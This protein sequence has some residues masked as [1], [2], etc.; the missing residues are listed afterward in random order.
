MSFFGQQAEKSLNHL[1][2]DKVILGADGFDMKAGITAYF[3]PE[4]SLN[5][6]MCAASSE[7]IAVTDSSKFNRRGGHVICAAEDIHTLIT[8]S[9]IPAEYSKWLAE[10]G[11]ELHK[12]SLN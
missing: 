5:R 4:A 10:A 9:G 8:D 1:H 11:V 3:E 7:V 12:V 6:L 2:F